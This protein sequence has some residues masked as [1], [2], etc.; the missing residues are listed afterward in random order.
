VSGVDFSA[1]AQAGRFRPDRG[2]CG[3]GSKPSPDTAQGETTVQTTLLRTGDRLIIALI[4][5]AGF[6]PISSTGASSGRSSEAEA[7]RIVGAQVPCRGALDARLAAGAVACGFAP[8]WSAAPTILA[9]VRWPISSMWI[10]S[11][12]LDARRMARH[13]TD[14]STH[15]ARSRKLDRQ[16]RIDWPA[17]TGGV[18]TWVRWRSTGLNLT[19]RIVLHDAGSARHARM[20][21]IA[22]GGECTL[23]GGSGVRGDGNLCCPDAVSVSGVVRPTADGIRP[24]AASHRRP[25]GRAL[26]VDLDGILSF[27]ARTPRVSMA[28]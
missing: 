11:R 10:Q 3:A 2:L 23:A 25:R 1:A 17:S 26:T 24:R 19:G 14:P 28:P 21:D 16:G 20:N 18:Q 5:G 6:G 9:K 4:A 12:L 15:G 7:T 8:W 22:F 13:R 27:D